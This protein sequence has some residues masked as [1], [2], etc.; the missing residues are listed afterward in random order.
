[1]RASAIMS[2]L[3]R[4][5]DFGG[6][7][8]TRTLDPGIMRKKIGK[9]APQIPCVTQPYPPDMA[10]SGLLR[11]VAW[12]MRPQ[13]FRHPLTGK[14]LGELT[15]GSLADSAPSRSESGAMEAYVGLTSAIGLLPPAGRVAP[16]AR[17]SP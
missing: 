13:T 2:V 6:K 12:R 9:K 14:F 10:V 11:S 15:G 7:G 5:C 8:G 3:T 1:M 16:Q 17:A 4:L